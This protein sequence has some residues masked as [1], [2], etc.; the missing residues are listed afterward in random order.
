VPFELADLDPR[1]RRSI[2]AYDDVA[3]DYQRGLRTHRPL[4]DVRRFG[5]DLP[6]GTVVLDAGCGPANDI[7]LLRDQGLHVIGLDLS[8]GALDHA[9]L[10]L[11]RDGLVRGPI[12]DPPFADASFGG[13]WC[14]GG[15]DH[16]PRD[17]WRTVFA[18]LVRT[19]E[20]GPVMFACY[21]GSVDMVAVSD[22]LLGTVHVSAATEDEV[23]GMFE[24]R[25]L[26]DV[27]VEVR[28]DPLHGRRRP[29]LVAHG[30]RPA[31]QD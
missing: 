2:E 9:R 18:A 19:L 12:D 24:E 27:R 31:G 8:A 7:R 5:G 23:I 30:R 17:R 21:R 16:T 11:P 29:K 14:N 4:T 13:L 25:G 26:V 3:A 28:P 1:T 15:L 22:D 10:L 20:S 6:R